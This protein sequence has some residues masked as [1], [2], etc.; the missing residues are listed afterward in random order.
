MKNDPKQIAPGHIDDK[1]GDWFRRF[2]LNGCVWYQHMK[3]H[4]DDKGN[5][6]RSRVVVLELV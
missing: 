6:I 3:D 1:R 2:P 5:I 4:K